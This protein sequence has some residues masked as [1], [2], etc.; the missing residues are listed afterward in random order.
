MGDT[1]V[2][3]LE[4]EIKMLRLTQAVNQ[5][6]LPKEAL[7]NPD[8]IEEVPKDPLDE[9]MKGMLDM[10]NQT[11]E[12]LRN[13]CADKFLTKDEYVDQQA[14]KDYENSMLKKR[15]EA[16]AND[17]EFIKTT[18]FP[19]LER[20]MKDKLDGVKEVNALIG[21]DLRELKIWKN[22]G[23]TPNASKLLR[24]AVNDS[25]LSGNTDN[26]MLERLS[27]IED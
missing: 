16:V 19:A 2:K 23:V 25:A 24:P 5:G 4:N 8:D 10:I 21:E 18:R 11:G 27:Q 1:K 3:K 9:M 13:S 22:G 15:V 6:T 14:S 7:D 20:E 17:S 26:T 12:D